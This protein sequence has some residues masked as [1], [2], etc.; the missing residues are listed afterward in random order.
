MKTKKQSFLTY[1][2]S[3]NRMKKQVKTKTLYLF[4]IMIFLIAGTSAFLISFVNPTP[5]IDKINST[6]IF[7]NVSTPT[8]NPNYAFVDF[9]G[10]LISLWRLEPKNGSF[11]VDEMGVNNASC[12]GSACPLL[13]TNGAFNSSYNFDG[14]NDFVRVNNYNYSMFKDKV[15]MS[16]WIKRVNQS[17]GTPA[18]F[19]S[20][21]AG[22]VGWQ[23]YTL[24]GASG[25]YRVIL[26]DSG[27]WASCFAISST[28]YGADD[29][30]W[31][32]IGFTYNGTLLTLYR[33]G[34][35]I[36]TDDCSGD[37]EFAPGVDY[38]FGVAGSSFF[39]GSIDEVVL[40]NRSLSSR[41]ML[42]LYNATAN[43][44][45]NNYTGL[46][47]GIHTFKAYSVNASG[48][49][50]QTELRTVNLTS[51]D[52][53]VTG[54]SF[55]NPTPTSGSQQNN[56]NF[57][58]ATQ[59]YPNDTAYTLLNIDNSLVGW[60]RFDNVSTFTDELGILNGTCTTCPVSNQS[61]RYN[62][63]I[64]FDGQ[65]QTLTVPVTTGLDFNWNSNFSISFWVNAR[66]NNPV[67]L[68]GVMG[69][70]QSAYRYWYLAYDAGYRFLFRMSN[71]NRV[72]DATSTNQIT[73]NSWT[74]VVITRDGTYN[75]FY[76]NTVLSNCVNITDPFIPVMKAY[77]PLP[78][79]NITIGNIGRGVGYFMNG[80]LD[81]LAVFSRNLSQAEINALYNSSNSPYS[82]NFNL[83]NNSIYTFTAYGID[84]RGN[85][86]YTETRNVTIGDI[87]YP[88]FSNYLDNSLRLNGTG[89]ATFN[90]TVTNANATVFLF[91]NGNSYLATNT[92][93]TV[94]NYSLNLNA[95]NYSYYWY[96]VGNGFNKLLNYSKVNYYI[97]NKSVP[98]P[99]FSTIPSSTTVNYSNGIGVQF[100]GNDLYGFGSFKLGFA[101]RYRKLAPAPARATQSGFETVGDGL[102]LYGGDNITDNYLEA[103]HRYNATTNS[104]VTLP[105]A[106]AAMVGRQSVCFETYQNK[107]IMSGGLWRSAYP[108]SR[109]DT[110]IY[111]TATSTWTQ[112]SNFSYWTEDLGCGRID[113]AIYIF[114]GVSGEL[115]NQYQKYNI[116]TDTWTFL[117]S[118][119]EDV[120]RWSGNFVSEYN[121]RLYLIGSEGDIQ[122]YPIYAALPVPKNNTAVYDPS[123]DSFSL[124][125][126]MN[127]TVGY[128]EVDTLNDEMIVLGGA[129]TDAGTGVAYVQIL[130]VTSNSWRIA[131]SQIFYGNT[132]GESQTVY[133]GEVYTTGGQDYVKRLYKYLPHAE[134]YFTINSTGF[135]KNR[136]AN[137][138]I[139]NYSIQ[140]I[141]N[142][143]NGIVNTTTYKVNVYDNVPP[144]NLS[145]SVNKSVNGTN[146]TSIWYDDTEMA[147]LTITVNNQ[148]YSVNSSEGTFAIYLNIT[149]ESNYSYTATDILGNR[150]YTS[151]FS[152][153]TPS[154]PT[155]PST[156]NVP[157]S[158]GGAVG[159]NP[160]TG[161]PY[162]IDGNLC[163]ITLD[164]IN[165]YGQYDFS[166]VNQLVEDQK[167]L[168]NSYTAT[169]V[170]NYLMSWQPYCSDAIF[171]TLK[172]DLV[173]RKVYY[174][175]LDNNQSYNNAEL[176]NLQ[177]NLK[178]DVK[179]SLDVL[180]YYSDNYDKLCYSKTNLKLPVIKRDV[181]T[182][183]I[184][185]INN[186]RC[187]LNFARDVIG[188]DLDLAIPFFKIYL[189]QNTQ[190]NAIN[191]FK[192]LFNLESDTQG[193]YINGVRAYLLI[194]PIFM[195][196]IYD[197]LFSHHL[198][199]KYNKK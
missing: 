191:S 175:L 27:A 106:P 160:L 97:L 167:L 73:Q 46:G 50:N 187:A 194:V 186:T 92:S 52:V 107:I 49:M 169:T 108:N 43:Q 102:Y 140:V 178:D 117:G 41:E 33:N 193:I 176:F 183:T 196:L 62:G 48:F 34:V 61:G 129:I 118:M 195:F 44:L 15:S 185:D 84:I 184:V 23:L 166:H 42:S 66:G 93:S 56:T 18:L 154:I 74:H 190:C 98:A 75:C 150:V 116:T 13:D 89:K 115:M 30:K 179:V 14:A 131:P 10:S 76:I 172:E 21:T 69:K 138:P 145:Q 96:A 181:K 94:F 55:V 88:V 100:V 125:D 64:S 83:N 2:S 81:E 162:V 20:N 134:D 188:Y 122:S 22:T 103:F 168:N 12:T 47:L 95:G 132:A 123:T 63:S 133:N 85:K 58:I 170:M 128:K 5:T 141:I 37:I 111:D 104:W 192:Y 70:F 82:G 16:G 53:L 71:G 120:K 153:E 127:V 25:D 57:S 1:E 99:Y 65:T 105:D 113:D 157:D 163:N 60:W 139:G 67:S 144:L 38:D 9:D 101:D 161:K 114:G 142:N 31:V 124:L 146:F 112:K 17:S 91:I 126:P 174:F 11:F 7:I 147:N 148:N 78:N 173:C 36:V 86:T 90:V 136:T 59:F 110:W 3:L 72:L 151:E 152:T 171:R 28:G 182:L 121:N 87:N 135:L 137:V 79:E 80:S 19:T 39:N 158:S 119:S 109:N 4:V 24:A 180:R 156:S 189:P 130:N 197:L 45:S 6:S 199:K 149:T 165:N 177:Q 164:Y 26:K 29:G 198:L 77:I 68:S 155:P 51:S 159:I 35:A 54:L 32:N 8:T 143:S 40:F